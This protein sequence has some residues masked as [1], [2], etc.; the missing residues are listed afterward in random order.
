MNTIIIAALGL[1]VLVVLFAVFTGRIGSF[2]E[3]VGQIDNCANK[4]AALGK[5]MTKAKDAQCNTIGG[6]FI[7]G[8]YQDASDDDCCCKDTSKLEGA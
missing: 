6:D 7:P 3:G 2:S 4:C 8:S 1:A 5:E